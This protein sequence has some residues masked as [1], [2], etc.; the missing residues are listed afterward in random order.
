[1]I[2]AQIAK[3]APSYQH[4]DSSARRSHEQGSPPEAAAPWS[5]QRGA[6]ATASKLGMATKQA[7]WDGYAA[8]RNPTSGSSLTN[9]WRV[10]GVPS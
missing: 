3:L 5:Q 6:A 9:R 4:P 1:L 7:P 8:G 10:V 2:K